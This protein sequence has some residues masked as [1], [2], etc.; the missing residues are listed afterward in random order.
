MKTA[1]A[2]ACLCSQV[3]YT[4]SARPL[5]MGNCHCRDCQRS[6]GGAYTPAMFFRLEAVA[7]TGVVRYYRKQADSGHAIERGFCPDC[8]SQ[9]FSRLERQP[10]LIGVRAGTLDDPALFKP[11]IDIFADSANHWDLLNP[12]LPRAARSPQG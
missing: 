1:F 9:L 6:S 4:C 3:R 12:E 8:G 10:G 7:I 11:A 5:F 2:G